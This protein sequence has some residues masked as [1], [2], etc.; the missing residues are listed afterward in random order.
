MGSG[1][2]HVPGYRQQSL[3]PAAGTSSP[4]AL[5]CRRNT[6]SI[7]H[8]APGPVAKPARTIP[9]RERPGRSSSSGPA[10][11]PGRR[12]FPGPGLSFMPPT[13]SPTAT[14]SPSRPPSPFRRSGT[15]SLLPRRPRRFPPGRGATPAPSKTTPGSSMR[16]RP[17]G[18][19]QVT[20][21]RPS[22]VSARPA[23][24]PRSWPGWGSA[25]RERSMTRRPSRA[26]AAGSASPARVVAGRGSLRGPALVSVAQRSTRDATTSG[27]NAARGCRCVARL[28]SRT[29]GRGSSARVGN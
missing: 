3:L 26:T 8:P 21:E 22:A 17:R 4:R 5:G 7:P 6:P 20:R 23:I 16:S 18:R 13:C 29:E 12:R 15:R 1:E 25:F 10:S 24:W 2:Y 14:C 19:W 28:L 11:A 27:R 9:R